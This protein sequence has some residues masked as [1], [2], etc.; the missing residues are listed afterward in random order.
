M[1]ESNF[2][3][4]DTIYVSL[5]HDNKKIIKKYLNLIDLIFKKIKLCETNQENINLLLK[6][7][8]CQT[9]FKRLN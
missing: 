5:A 8:V 1:L 6:T 7:D 9:S 4:T 3:A 2:L